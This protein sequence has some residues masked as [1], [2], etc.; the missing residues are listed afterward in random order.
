MVFYIEVLSSEKQLSP[1]TG[2]SSGNNDGELA[3]VWLY[4]LSHDFSRSVFQTQNQMQH[5]KGGT[6]LVI[7]NVKHV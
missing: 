6:I 3:I 7:S 4:L 1:A 2:P 5:I